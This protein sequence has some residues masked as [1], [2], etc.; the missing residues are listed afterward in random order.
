MILKLQPQCLSFESPGPFRAAVT[1]RPRH[2]VSELQEKLQP[3]RLVK[4]VPFFVNLLRAG[5]KRAS[6]FLELVYLYTFTYRLQPL[7]IL[8]RTTEEGRRGR[9]LPL[10]L[11]C[12]HTLC[13]HCILSIGKKT[14]YV[15]CPECGVTRGTLRRVDLKLDAFC[16]ITNEKLWGARK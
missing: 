9:R 12:G 16:R 4:L 3:Q 6:H 13:S 7:L 15:S 8:L 2:G 11:W 10:V 5:F 14:S 1:A